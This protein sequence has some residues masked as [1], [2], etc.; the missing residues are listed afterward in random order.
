MTNDNNF[1]TYAGRREDALISYLYDEIDAETRTTFERHLAT[2]AR[3]RTELQGLSSVRGE[4]G[5]WT[6]PEYA[7]AV[8]GGR[9][10]PFRGRTSLTTAIR[11]LPAWAQVAAATL[12]FAAAAGLANVR[13]AYTADGV[14]VRTGWLHQDRDVVSSAPPATTA[15]SA[16]WRADLTALEQ[17]L[18]TALASVQATAA[19]TANASA[20]S[21]SRK[22]IGPQQVQALIEASERRQQRE[23]AL[24]VAEVMRDVQG[25]RQADLTKIDYVLGIMQSRTGSEVM[26]TQRQVNSLAQQV[27][28]RP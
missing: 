13:V 5:R 28:Q 15:V 20:Q 3:C 18:Q 17:Q 27:S 22:E 23:L 12:L 21:E 6:S 1:C 7:G 19:K 10:L 16:P 25:Q 24:R 14:T 26:R 2:C 9:L 4:L 8:G 11:D